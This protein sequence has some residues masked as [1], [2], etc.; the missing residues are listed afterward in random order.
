MYPESEAK[1][2]MA[3]PMEATLMYIMQL[4]ESNDTV[5]LEYIASAILWAMGNTFG[6]QNN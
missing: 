1:M 4:K 6:E 5:A 2:K 3:S